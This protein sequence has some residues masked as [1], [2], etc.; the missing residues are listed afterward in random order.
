MQI[1]I[2]MFDVFPFYL[3]SLVGNGTASKVGGEE[4]M[5]SV[6]ALQ[7]LSLASLPA[8]QVHVFMCLGFQNILI[9]HVGHNM[10]SRPFLNWLLLQ[11]EPKCV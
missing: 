7:E 4:T 1:C 3:I 5:V 10:S 6:G 2:Y 8:P 11:P 9:S